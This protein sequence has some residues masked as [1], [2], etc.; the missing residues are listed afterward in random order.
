VDETL[1][2]TTWP[3]E[4]LVAMDRD[5]DHIFDTPDSQTAREVAHFFEEIPQR[6]HD[7]SIENARLQ[8]ES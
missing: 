4:K 8:C 2:R 7:R 5:L 3:G 6:P 1:A